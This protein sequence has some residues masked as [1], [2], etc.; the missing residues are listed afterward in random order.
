MD[1]YGGFVALLGALSA[2]RGPEFLSSS[3]LRQR[4]KTSL[5]IH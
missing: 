2:S 4:E 5:Y 1:V 3:T